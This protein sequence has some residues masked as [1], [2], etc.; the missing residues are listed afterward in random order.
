M[1]VVI[2]SVHCDPMTAAKTDNLERLWR[3]IYS[4]YSSTKLGREIDVTEILLLWHFFYS[5]FASNDAADIT[6]FT[7]FAFGCMTSDAG[8]N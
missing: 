2:L 6:P 4:I 8:N 5:N 3:Q 1:V 7:V